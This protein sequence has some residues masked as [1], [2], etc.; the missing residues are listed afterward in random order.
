MIP[1]QFAKRYRVTLSQLPCWENLSP[2][3]H[4][5]ACADLIAEIEA[6]TQAERALSGKACVGAAAVLSQ[7]PHA[8]PV[9]T[10]RSPAPFVHAACRL[11]RAA[12][13]QAYAAF[14]DAFRAAAECL[15]R[16]MKADFPPGAF[17]PGCPFVPALAQGS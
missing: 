15:G 11:V 7:N 5:G 8:M 17:P 14:V 16:G 2:A 9:E 13:R 1:G 4:R 6:E 10:D 12:F 3:Q